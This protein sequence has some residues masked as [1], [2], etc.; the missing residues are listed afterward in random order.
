MFSLHLIPALPH[1]RQG[2]SPK[3]QVASPSSALPELYLTG[4]GVGGGTRACSLPSL[5]SF[6]EP[7]EPGSSHHSLSDLAR[8]EKSLTLLMVH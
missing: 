4:E 3:D 2:V 8:S 6:R 1:A 7:R 5:L